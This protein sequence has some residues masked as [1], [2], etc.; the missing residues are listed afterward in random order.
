MYLLKKIIG[1]H[2]YTSTVVALLAIIVLGFAWTSFELFKRSEKALQASE[3]DL[4][5]MRAVE[6]T[7]RMW[8]RQ[9]TFSSFLQAWHVD[10]EEGARRAGTYMT[11]GTRE[12]KA[13]EFLLDQR[14]LEE[15]EA[16]FRQSV[17]EDNPGFA[18]MIVGEFHLKRGE[19]ARAFKAY[20]NGYEI[21]THLGKT[22]G[23]RDNWLKNYI[24]SRLYEVKK[25]KEG[26]GST[27]VNDS[28][29]SKT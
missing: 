17:S 27:L 20:E 25:R 13:I 26:S 3:T 14:P 1:R 24:T 28:E 8:A 12:Y 18:D 6:G 21:I 19:L 2:R 10:W 29:G 16:E 9:M 11:T 4:K 23:F 5:N 22:T 15:K 7:N